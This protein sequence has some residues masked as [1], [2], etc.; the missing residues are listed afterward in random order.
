MD[1]L[2]YGERNLTRNLEENDKKNPCGALS[3]RRE[4]KFWKVLKKMVWTS[5]IWFFKNLIHEFWLIE[6]Q[7]R[8]I[9]TDRGSLKNFKTIS[10]QLWLIEKQFRSIETDRGLFFDQ[11]KQTEASL[12]NLKEFWLIEK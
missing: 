1:I 10:K 7:F 8:L 11:S 12:D 6:N 4:K 2:A 3:S 9:E 5:Q